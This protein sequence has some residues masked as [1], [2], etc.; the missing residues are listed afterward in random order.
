MKSP[1][2]TW[3]H[4]DH[5][6]ITMINMMSQWHHQQQCAPRDETIRDRG[7]TRSTW[8]KRVRGEQRLTGSMT[9]VPGGPGSPS[10]PGRPAFPDKPCESHRRTDGRYVK[11]ELLCR[12]LS[13]EAQRKAARCGTGREHHSPSRRDLRRS[14]EARR[15]QPDQEDP[16]TTGGWDSYSLC[17][18]TSGR[19]VLYN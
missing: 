18:A 8:T 19:R 3:H 12:L 11:D 4:H 5:N 16:G 10:A 13:P 9:E 7:R 14:Q 17:T 2:S 15:I 6:E 1:W